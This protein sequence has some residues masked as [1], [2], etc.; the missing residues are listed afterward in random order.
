MTGRINHC[1]KQKQCPAAKKI[2]NQM[3]YLRHSH[4]YKDR[5]AQWRVENPERYQERVGTYF[6]REDIKD[7]ARARTK[8]WARDNVEK[9]KEFDQQWRKANRARDRANKARYR[10]ATRK[11]TPSWLTEEQRSQIVA[12]YIEAE[13]LTRETGIEHEVDHIHPLQA[14]CA[15]GLH[16]PWNLRVVPRDDNNR[17]P[18]KW[19]SEE[20]TALEKSLIRNATQDHAR[21]CLR[22]VV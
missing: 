13:R 6:S 8:Q 17:R 18:R 7:A 12:F 15:C 20:L 3:H 9:K 19:T 10:A 11:A 14:D 22:L 4:V 1:G 2:T 21:V 16:V 5:A